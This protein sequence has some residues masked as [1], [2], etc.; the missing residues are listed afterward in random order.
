M[1]SGASSLPGLHILLFQFQK[2]VRPRGPAPRVSL[3]G[4]AAVRSSSSPL[5]CFLSQSLSPPNSK[6]IQ[7][8]VT[9]YIYLC[10]AAR[11][12]VK[13]RRLTCPLG[14]SM[15]L[16]FTALGLLLLLLRQDRYN[17]FLFLSVLPPLGPE[18][19][20]FLGGVLCPPLLPPSSFLIEFLAL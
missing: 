11:S 16:L 15:A 5:Y 8:D 13:S 2:A 12:V 19:F 1:I 9:L 10:V 17:S 18:L 20:I 14:K 3:A 7:S 4:G 6:S